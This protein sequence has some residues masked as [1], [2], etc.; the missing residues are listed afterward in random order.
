[1]GQCQTWN[2]GALKIAAYGLVHGGVTSLV[3]GGVHN[4][5]I[6]CQVIGLCLHAR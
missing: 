5:C 6:L 1:M 4:A 2:A 3:L